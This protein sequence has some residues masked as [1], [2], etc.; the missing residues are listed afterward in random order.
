MAA[1]I[2]FGFRVF[3]IFVFNK[4][5]VIAIVNIVCVLA[6]EFVAVTAAACIALLS[7]VILSLCVCVGVD[8][9]RAVVFAH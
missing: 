3:K 6:C 4:L 9:L 7:D 2:R 1:V 8:R 5:T